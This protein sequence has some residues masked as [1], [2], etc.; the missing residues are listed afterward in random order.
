MSL[1]Q[2]SQVIGDSVR[3][4][5]ILQG[6]WVMAELSDVRMSGGHCYMELVE[7]NAAGATIAKLRATVWAGQLRL[8]RS[9]FFAATG[10]DLG[11]GIKVMLWGAVGHHP[12]YGLAFSVGDIDPSYTL[13][14]ME[15]LRRE[16]LQRLS[17]EGLLDLNRRLALPLNPQRIA[18]VSAAGAAGYGDFVNQLSA[19]S[20]HFQFYPFLF[21]AVMQ[22][23]RTAAS[24]GAA[25]DLVEKSIDLWDCVVIIR[26]GGATTDLNG[27]D[28]YE[29]ARKVATFPLPV[30]VGIGH[31]RD[32]TV[33][34]EIAH[35]R[36]K[37]P[38]AVAAFL[39]DSL[40]S[41][42]TS[43]SASTDWIMRYA[44][45][46]LQGEKLRLH[47][48]ETMIPALA[49][50]R[51]AS[52]GLKLEA[53]ASH[54]PVAVASRTASASA[55]LEST[56]RLIGTLASNAADRCHRRI[57][58]LSRLVEALS[59]LNTL[60]RGYSVT[61]LNGKAVTSASQISPGAKITTILFDGKLESEVSLLRQADQEHV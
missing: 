49:S 48:A 22:G 36:C 59:P 44:S 27:F 19:N 58:S 54:I 57:E 14:D 5:P 52:A 30:I 46:R 53:V 25:L 26:G 37:T 43:L 9:K 18:V 7:K 47:N 4:V 1:S 29:L 24:V 21:P 50:Q 10:R 16:I 3:A 35:T 60:R 56:A 6:A 39:V 28:N 20:E 38:T 32:R 13:G 17:S 12:V 61:R 2:L 41:A 45:N 8:I 23:E 15:R 40:R 34:D 51:I 11:S 33:L 42:F 31:E 55:R